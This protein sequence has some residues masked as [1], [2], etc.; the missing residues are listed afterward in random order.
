M[1]STNAASDSKRE[2]T[3]AMRG[4][5]GWLVEWEALQPAIRWSEM[6]QETGFP[7]TTDFQAQQLT[8]RRSG[9]AIVPGIRR[10][11]R[12]AK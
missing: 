8:N 5:I 7:L 9:T 12:K 4:S 3:D 6:D 11:W 2:F 1:D 10:V